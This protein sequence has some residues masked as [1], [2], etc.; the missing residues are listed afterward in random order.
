MD[1]GIAPALPP[2]L[3]PARR[4]SRRNDALR[5][6]ALLPRRN[7][8]SRTPGEFDEAVKRRLQQAFDVAVRAII[9]RVAF[10]AGGADAV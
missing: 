10:G 4:R 5:G 6:R 1:P 7:L 8:H 3:G 9:D 2:G